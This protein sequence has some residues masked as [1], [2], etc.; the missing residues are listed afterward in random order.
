[1]LVGLRCSASL[2]VVV[3]GVTLLPPQ[4]PL[5]GAQEPELPCPAGSGIFLSP[6]SLCLPKSTSANECLL[7]FHGDHGSL[8]PSCLVTIQ[9]V[10][11]S[12]L[13][14]LKPHVQNSLLSFYYRFQ[15]P[16]W[17]QGHF[18]SS[19]PS[20]PLSSQTHKWPGIRINCLRPVPLAS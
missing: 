5:F 18:I 7:T 20:L 13:C 3:M 1:M 15:N 8:H 2:S 9:F 14:R 19:L 12:S 17:P 16:R 4:G 10:F 6:V 11:P